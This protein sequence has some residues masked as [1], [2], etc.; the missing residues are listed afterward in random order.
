MRKI[1]FVIPWYG[2]N[3]PGGAE[4][5]F[6]DVTTQL[7]R[8]GVELEIIT[9][10]VEKFN[11]DWSYNFH[12]PGL[13]KNSLGIPVRRFEADKRDTAAFD[14]INGKICGG[15]AITR[16]EEEVFMREMVNSKAM[17]EYLEKHE[18]EYEA[19]VGIPYMFGPVYQ[20]AL[21][22]PE[23]TLLIPCFHDEGYAYMT[24]FQECFSKVAGMFF[25]ARPEAEL[26]KRLYGLD[27]VIQCTAGLGMDV[28]ISGDGERFRKTFQISEPFMLYAGRKDKLKNVDTLLSFFRQYKRRNPGP[29]KLV[30][31]GGGELEI[32]KD[33]EKEILDL[34]FVSI[35]DKYNAYK[36]AE[37]LCQPS[38]NE[39]FSYVIMESWLMERPVL[40]HEDC[41]VTKNFVQEAGGGLYFKSYEDFEGC[42][43]YFRL[44]KKKADQMGENGRSFVMEHFRWEVV[45]QKYRNVF[46]EI[47]ERNGKKI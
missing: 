37:I 31:I 9:T 15:E 6:R 13:T 18:A 26:A 29:F 11:S 45:L 43:N 40:V 8:D 3:I 38:H 14:K 20:T 46:R 1:G 16:E 39:S 41:A 25:N 47:Q 5:A 32:P 10:C 28:D 23:K 36:A 34:G 27:G 44:N 24:V 30:L 21:R 7:Y 33:A 2:E 12:K 19:F 22:F 42:V 17:Y 4:N 35:Q